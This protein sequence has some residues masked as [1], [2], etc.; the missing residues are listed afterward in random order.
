[1]HTTY[2]FDVV[3]SGHILLVPSHH[4]SLTTEIIMFSYRSTEIICFVVALVCEIGSRPSGRK[5][6][7][8]GSLRNKW[9]YLSRNESEC[10][11]R[12]SGQRKD[13]GRTATTATWRWWNA[14]KRIQLTSSKK[15]RLQVGAC[16]EPSHIR[17]VPLLPC[18]HRS[19]IPQNK[20]QLWLIMSL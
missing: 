18:L 1:M 4:L 13:K 12:A 20:L 9:H 14:S 2:T 17:F 7:R 15:C 5:W 8:L 3:A 6:K 19:Q 10:A 16:L 11:W